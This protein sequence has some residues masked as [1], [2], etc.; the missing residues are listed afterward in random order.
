MAKESVPNGSPSVIRSVEEFH[1]VGE[2]GD[3]F[4]TL[5][6][7]GHNVVGSSIRRTVAMDIP[8]VPLFREHLNILLFLRGLPNVPLYTTDRPIRRDGFHHLTSRFIDSLTGGHPLR[9]HQ[10]WCIDPVDLIPLE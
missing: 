9:I 10:I 7:E 5:S 6:S 8:G 3:T 1:C 4:I 2:L